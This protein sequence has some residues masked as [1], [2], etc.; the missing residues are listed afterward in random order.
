M[1]KIFFIRELSYLSPYVIVLLFFRLFEISSRLIFVGLLSYITQNGFSIIFFLL[2]DLILSG[3]LQYLLDFLPINENYKSG[4]YLKNFNNI[5][6]T[7]KC[8]NKTISLFEIRFYYPFLKLGNLVA[9]WIPI[10][11]LRLE[12]QKNLIFIIILLNL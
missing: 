3:Y 5:K 1:D 8:C 2:A 7:K 9:L 6:N 12:K 4:I 10:I 11:E